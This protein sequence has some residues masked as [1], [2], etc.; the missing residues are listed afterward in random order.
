MRAATAPEGWRTPRRWREVRAPSCAERP[1]V[2]R[3][4]AAVLARELT[5]ISEPTLLIS[6]NLQDLDASAL[7]YRAWPLDTISRKDI[8]F[9]LLME[10]DQV[11]ADGIVDPQKWDSACPK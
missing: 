6:N 9:I 3:P 8:G 7:C 1:G 5:R 4:S 10:P 2:Q 11:F